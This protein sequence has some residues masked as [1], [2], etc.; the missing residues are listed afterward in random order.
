MSDTDPNGNFTSSWVDYLQQ[1]GRGTMDAQ[2][3]ITGAAAAG[4]LTGAIYFAMDFDPARSTDPTT[5]LNRISEATAL[6]QVDKYFQDVSAFFNNYNQSH[7]TS[8]QIG[9][10]GAGDVL[11]KIV[12]DPSIT[13]GGSHAFTWLAAP[14][15]WPGYQTFTTWDLKQYDNDQ[16]QL[17][18]HKVD[19]DQSSGG[20]F[21]EW[22]VA[23]SR[24]ENDYAGITR[25]TLPTDQANDIASA[26]NTGSQTETQYV[27][28]LLSQVGNTT[29]PAVAIE[30]S[31][32]GSV[33]SSAEITSL[34]TQFLPA[35]VANAI[36]NGFNPQVY[37]SEALGLAF[38]FG[39]EAG[40]TSFANLFGP[41]NSAMPNSAAGDAAFAIA[42]SSAIFGSAS[43]TNLSNVLD[44]FV[45]NW[46]AFY[47]GNG[48]PGIEHASPTQI[49]I[50]ARAAA[51]GDA[52]GVALFNNLGPLS[53]QAT[54]F[55]EDAAQGSAT[56]S[57]SLG[58]QPVHSIFQGGIAGAST[59]LSN[60]D[61]SVIGITS[62]AD[63][64]V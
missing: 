23:S 24:I 53:A 58:N 21:G 29:I 57:A 62:H 41:S 47:S 8:Y 26:I 38:A 6:N 34:V 31:M 9:V 1:A 13:A 32:Y 18:G 11:S 55:L 52:V 64:I 60:S 35:Q 49:D 33:G 46:K 4:Q 3:A 5:G 63:A 25:V 36:S 44:G 10:Y 45:A 50:A 56:Y 59:T 51:W 7:G 42:A 61:A 19:L 17:D 28:G 48:V 54:N 16:F 40:S 43:T 15:A 14:T 12:S 22:G 37:A 2:N 20:Q 39:N 27:T 30:A